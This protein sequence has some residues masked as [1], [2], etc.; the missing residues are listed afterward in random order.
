MIEKDTQTWQGTTT[1]G[2]VVTTIVKAK[3]RA[4]A[5]RGVTECVTLSHMWCDLMIDD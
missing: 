5:L 2:L 1:G 3:R 4:R